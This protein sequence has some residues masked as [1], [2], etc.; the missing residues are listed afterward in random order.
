MKTLFVQEL[1]EL[2][3]VKKCTIH[4]IR[5]NREKTYL[6]VVDDT[7]GLVHRMP[8]F[9][10]ECVSMKETLWS[11]SFDKASDV[12]FSENNLLLVASCRNKHVLLFSEAHDKIVSTINLERYPLEIHVMQNN[13]F[14]LFSYVGDQQRSYFLEGYTLDGGK[15]FEKKIPTEKEEAGP[16]LAVSTDNQ[17][18]L[19][20]AFMGRYLIMKFNGQGKRVCTF[21]RKMNP[22]LV[23]KPVRRFQYTESTGLVEVECQTPPTEGILMTSGLT[24]EPQEQKLFTIVQGRY[25]DV[26][27]LSLNFQGLLEIPFGSGLNRSLAVCGK[28]IYSVFLPS[29][30][31]AFQYETKEE[32]VL[33]QHPPHD[34]YGCNFQ[35]LEGERYTEHE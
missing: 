27:D 20:P 7:C 21:E 33:L 13:S 22:I 28:T 31:G 8:L 9:L 26:F 5:I 3:P 34:F 18:Y 29:F 1:K 25:I 11:R 30:I 10:S 32:R 17:I 35:S 2:C 4:S 23:A 6:Y 19:A 15:I 16:G 14:A 24:L 12:A